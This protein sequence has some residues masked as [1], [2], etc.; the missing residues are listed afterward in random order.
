MVSEFSCY[1][2][3][4]SDFWKVN[5]FLNGDLLT[6]GIQSLPCGYSENDPPLTC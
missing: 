3:M 1:E 2:F 4:V 6:T 5:S